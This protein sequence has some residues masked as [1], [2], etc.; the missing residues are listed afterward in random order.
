[1]PALSLQTY[2][3][4][5]RTW[6]TNVGRNISKI[7]NGHDIME[8]KRTCAG[9]VL[10]VGAGPSVT[11]EDLQLVAK[12]W[13]GHV[14]TT[15]KM[16]KP[17]LL[18][19]IKP[20]AVATLD[21][22]PLVGDFYKCDMSSVPRMNYLMGVHV[23]PDLVASFPEDK[24]Y[25]FTLYYDDP[26]QDISVTR[27]IAYITNKTIGPAYGNVGGLLWGLA[28]F[29]GHN[30]IVLIGID[31]GYGPSVQ[32][33]QTIYWNDFVRE[34]KSIKDVLKKYYKYYDNPFGLHVLTDAIFDGYRDTWLKQIDAYPS[35]HT[36][37]CSKF[38]TLFGA[39]ITCLDLEK[40]ITRAENGRL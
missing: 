11:S 31:L 5:E 32:P 38:T 6:F 7:R 26:E 35:V 8:L 10:I 33:P 13:Q 21:A 27:A 19:G 22:S 15:D 18:A 16:L 29:F 2:K 34:E 23:D 4:K 9:P 20:E 12:R 39:G 17:C 40:V 1:M 14:L 36:Y 37:N 3:G 25:W 24:T 30:K 28:E